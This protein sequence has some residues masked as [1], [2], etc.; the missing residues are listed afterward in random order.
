M[1]V[2]GL[3]LI[4]TLL[5]VEAY[6]GEERAA[7]LPQAFMR[8]PQVLAGLVALTFFMGI[9][10][11]LLSVSDVGGRLVSPSDGRYVASVSIPMFL[12]AMLIPK[13][14]PNA[15]P[16]NAR[17]AGLC[18]VESLL[19]MYSSISEDGVGIM[20]IGFFLVGVGSGISSSH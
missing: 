9:Q 10:T 1:V 19:L 20:Y 3:V 6:R 14:M 13:L 17:P 15:N 7:L 16:R 12:L 2:L 5:F 4:V 11:I 8:T 18:D